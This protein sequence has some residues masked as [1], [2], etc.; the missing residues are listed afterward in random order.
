M[1]LNLLTADALAD[2]NALA[3]LPAVSAAYDELVLAYKKEVYC[4]II[5]AQVR[6]A[7]QQCMDVFAQQRRM[8]AGS[9][10]HA[11]A[12]VDGVWHALG[13]GVEKQCGAHPGLRMVVQRIAVMFD[14]AVC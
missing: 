12:V 2:E 4:T 5:T 14:A 6:A 9:T 10:L 3:A 1:F 13:W 8:G 7:T 11:G